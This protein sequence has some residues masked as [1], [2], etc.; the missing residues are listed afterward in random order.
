M[1]DI[2]VCATC[3]SINR[4][5]DRQCYHCRA[6][7]DGAMA[8]VGPD[9][10]VES[11]VANRA[12]R[13]FLPTWPLAV[14]AG[15]LLTA[16]AVLGL[17]L[18]VA[19][20]QLYPQLREAFLVAL[21]TGREDA[22]AQVGTGSVALAPLSLLRTGLVLAA[23]GTF[24]AWLAVAT[25]N[26]PALG[27]GYPSRGP[28]RVFI[29]TLIPV[30]NLV[31]VP[32]MVQDVL[33]RV[34]P[35]AGGAFMVMA[36]TIGLVGSWLVSMVGGWIIAAAAIRSVLTAASVQAAAQIF[37]GVLDQSFVLGIITELMVTVGTIL[38][39]VLMTRIERRCMARDREIRGQAAG[40]AA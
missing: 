18:L 25:M 10:R 28:M 37:A 38:V 3:K 40:A 13:E 33:Y 16:V 34:D 31:K 4:Q 17:I 36:A 20:A 26:V 35:R 1:N 39:V 7:A 24:A 11:A 23:L 2:W 5:R 32:G 14:L 9:M 21:N 27:G 29:Y 6:S 19:Q 30:W 12:A 22:L 8:P 15:G